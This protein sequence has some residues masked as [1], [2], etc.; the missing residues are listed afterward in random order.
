MLKPSLLA[1]AIAQG[2]LLPSAR[3]ALITVNSANDGLPADDGSCTLREAIENA[4]TDSQNGR[5]S[6]GECAAGSGVDEI[7]FDP[8]LFGNVQ[9]I[10]LSQGEL[11]ISESLS[12]TGPG[13]DLLT[14]DANQASRHFNID[15][16][17]AGSLSEVSISDLS[18]SNG[19]VNGN[20]GAVLSRENLS[21]SR[22]TISGSSALPNGPTGGGAIY[23]GEA[24]T[25]NA[26][27]SLDAVTLSGNFARTWG[28][29]LRVEFDESGSVTVSNSAILDNFS[30]Q[31]GGGAWIRVGANGSISLQ[32]SQVND[33]E[34]VSNY[35]G[36][37]LRANGGSEILLSG[38]TLSGNLSRVIGGAEI[39]SYESTAGAPGTITLRDTIISGNSAEFGAAGL[40][41][42]AGPYVDTLVERTLIDG[43]TADRSVGG[44]NLVWSSGSLN[45]VNTIVSGNSSNERIGGLVLYNGTGQFELTG[46]AT[47]TDSRIVG[48]AANSIGGLYAYLY[49][50]EVSGANLTISGTEISGNTA[51]DTAGAQIYLYG[52]FSPVTATISNSTISGNQADRSNGGLRLRASREAGETHVSTL[53]LVDSTVTDN[54]ADLA[55]A[56]PGAGAGI[57]LYDIEP[58]AARLSLNRSIVAGNRLGG[59][60]TLVDVDA[61]GVAVEAAYSLIGDNTGS[62]L[63]EAPLGSP[64]ANGNLIGDPNGSG[65]IDPRLGPLTDNGGTTRSHASRASSPALD[66]AGGSCGGIDQRGVPRPQGE[67]CDMG[68]VENVDDLFK[69]RFEASTSSASFSNDLVW[70]DR[71]AL[72]SLLG[73]SSGP[74]LALQGNAIGSSTL[75]QRWAQVRRFDDRLELRLSRARGDRIEL[76]NWTPVTRPQLALHW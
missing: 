49:G 14:I 28:G 71:Q 34:S 39:R 75:Q 61:D 52:R 37:F 26:T 5:T 25:A 60:G 54:A 2:L 68:S 4:N 32:G 11:A 76:G 6:P 59:T 48:N 30:Q 33:N 41:S 7:G 10:S 19:A 15:D 36:L 23:A 46:T 56:T 42:A 9:L 8:G 47:I 27:L 66:A 50:S 55:A 20:G 3:A 57:R 45:I 53:E 18:L 31:S 13:R 43:N 65:I 74:V 64:D 73:P 1:I 69:D 35:G 62:S 58:G 67:A 38:T 24:G 29:A 22:S 16:G 72:D 21:L 70:L 44:A 17:V 51:Y 12:I 40:R 63:A